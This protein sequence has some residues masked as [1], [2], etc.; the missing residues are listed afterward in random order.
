MCGLTHGAIERTMDVVSE[1]CDPTGYLIPTDD[2]SRQL[3]EPEDQL[4]AIP[5][6]RMGQ[7]DVYDEKPIGI[8]VGDNHRQFMNPLYDADDDTYG[9]KALEGQRNNLICM[10]A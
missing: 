10:H 9:Q 3:N 4:P 5:H 1:S 2:Y 6:I 7:N 8:Q